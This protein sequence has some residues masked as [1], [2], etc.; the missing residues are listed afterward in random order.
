[1]N[2]CAFGLRGGSRRW[3]TTRRRGHEQLKA[4]VVISI[5]RDHSWQ[6]T[7][8][9]FDRHLPKLSLINTHYLKHCDKKILTVLPLYQ[10][11][12]LLPFP[13]KTSVKK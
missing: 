4:F 10:E 13:L 11:V 2:G 6:V 8:K 9:E 7:Q 5:I 12:Y 1:M 3:T